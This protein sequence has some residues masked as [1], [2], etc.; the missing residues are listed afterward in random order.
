MAEKTVAVSRERI[1]TCL[2]SL[3]PLFKI[4]SLTENQFESICSFICGREVY[5][6]LPTGSRK[7]VIFHLIP[8]VHTWM[9]H[10]S[11]SMQFK[12]DSI[13][14]I[15]CPLLSLMQDQVKFSDCG[16]KA[17]YIGGEQSE[18]TFQPIENGLF[19]Y[20]FISPES[21]LSNE[22][23]RNMLSSKVHEDKLVGFIV[24]E[25]HCMTEWGISSANNKK[26]VFC[27]WYS[28][29][30]EARSLT[31]VPFMALTVTATKATKDKIFELLEF[32]YLVEV[33]ASPNRNNISYCIQALDKNLTLA[34]NFRCVIDEILRKGRN[35]FRTIIYC[36]TMKQ[37]S[38]LYKTF[39]LELQ[40]SFYLDMVV[41]PL[42]RLVEML[43]SGT[44][45]N[46]IL[47]IHVNFPATLVI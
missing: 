41:N 6:S 45:I 33:L 42:N 44:P 17:V 38:I 47:H 15:I 39:E 5:I 4:K 21:A 19:T 25:V 29:I 18:E 23:W 8:L 14:L 28:R 37:C 32:T 10:N 24:D 27:K 13:I 40:Q 7:S 36:Q 30:N 26:H 16:L 2:D 34:E 20:V 12:E 22:R 31:K 43:H 11:N 3:L 46:V 35:S 1:R 9:F